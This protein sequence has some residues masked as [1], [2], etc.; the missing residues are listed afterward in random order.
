MALTRGSA[1]RSTH[2]FIPVHFSKQVAAK[3]DHVTVAGDCVNKDWE[4]EI[5]KSGDIVDIRE[6]GDITINDYTVDDTITAQTIS[7]DSQSLVIDQAKYF[8]FKFDYVDEAQTDLDVM[9]GYA[10]RAAIAVRNTVD[11]YLI[12]QMAAAV[13][14]A[15]IMGGTTKGSVIKITPAN[16]YDVMVDLYTLLAEAKVFS[17]TNEQPWVMWTPKF[18]GV[19]RKTGQLTQATAKGDEVIRN[20]YVGEF[21]GF[22]VKETTN[23]TQTAASGGNDDYFQILAG[24]TMAFTF[25]MQVAV[26]ED[27]NLQTTF[28]KA[29]RGLFVYGGESVVEE[30][31][32]KLVCKL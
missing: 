15:N 8:F 20:G 6:F 23:M 29:R 7:E 5:R 11:T 13:P 17:V 24:V 25:A 9:D 1:N 21:A 2:K 32:V 12:T 4:G 28:A 27:I 19:A 26:E 14:A 31:L 10:E 16:F 3:L 30:A 22:R 18:T